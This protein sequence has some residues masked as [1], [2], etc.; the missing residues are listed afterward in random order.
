MK[1][2]H[3]LVGGVIAASVLFAGA[4]VAGTACDKTPVAPQSAEAIGRDMIVNGVP[5]S[6]VG[7]QFD[8]TV[9]DVSKA[10]RAFWTA[11]NAPAKG[12]SS[13]SGLMLSAVDGNCLYLLNLPLQQEGARTRG[14][15]SVIRL[16]TD[17]ANHKIPDSAI[18]LPEE[19]KVLSDVESR[20]R[21]QTGRTWLLDMPG[22]SRW[23]AQRYRNRLALLGWV[24]VG[25]EPDYQSVGTRAPQGKAF[26][27][28]RGKDSVDA[29]FSDRGGRTVAVIN[30]T[31]NR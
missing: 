14:L 28:Q 19:S 27:M 4:A 24:N 12:R 6:V 18:P 26:A 9:D 20:D 25:R 13:A 17:E 8:G 1:C 30:A 31:R 5:T 22:E 23:N 21:G 7:M 3:Q 15:M 16:G 11:E 29:S 10:F 2:V